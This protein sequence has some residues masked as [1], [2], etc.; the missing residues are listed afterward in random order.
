[1]GGRMDPVITVVVALVAAGTLAAWLL[2]RGRRRMVEEDEWSPPPE[3]T[4]GTWAAEPIPQPFSRE[5]LLH[6]DRNLDPSKWDNTPDA[7]TDEAVEGDLP[8]HF[9][10]DDLRRRET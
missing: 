5:A 9:D 7:A 4:P 10:R 1:M 2:R 6:R 8:R 3:D